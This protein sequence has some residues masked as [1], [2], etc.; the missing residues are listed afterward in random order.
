VRFATA[1]PRV[2]KKLGRRVR[3]NAATVHLARL[4]A[5]IAAHDADALPTLFANEYDVPN[6][7]SAVGD[8]L[9]AA[10][11]TRDWAAVRAL[12]APDARF[13]DRGRRALVSGDVDWWIADLQEIASMRNTRFER[14][15]VGTAGDRVALERVLLSGDPGGAAAA[16]ATESQPISALGPFEL[17]ALWVTEVDESGRL[18]AGVAFDVDDWRAATREAYARWFA[19][20]AVAAASVGPVLELIEAFN[21]RDRTRLRAALA[22]EFVLDDHRP[23][24]LGLI[25]G[26]DVWAESWAG[27]LDLAPDAQI[28]AGSTLAYARYGSVGLPRIF[29]TLRDGGT[30][31]NPTASVAIVADGR[32]TRL[33]LFEPEHVE[34]A[35]ARFAELRPD[36]LRIRPNAFEELRPDP[37]RIPPNAAS[38]ARDRTFEAWTVG[39]W[40]A[41]RSLASDDFTFEDR[42]KRA[43]VSGDVE[44]WIRNNQFVQSGS[45][46]R[47]VRELIGTAGDR[48]ALERIL[49]TGGADGSPVERE[50]LRLTEVDADGRLRASIRFDLDDRRAAFAEAHARFAAGEAA[51]TVAQ[52]PIVAY[53]VASSRSDWETQLRGCLARDVVV[54]DHRTLGFGISTGDELIERWRAMMN[55]APD[56][57]AEVFRILAWNRH[58]RVEA[59]RIG[60]TMPYG[61]GPFENVIVRVIVTDGDRIQRYEVFDTCD[62]DRALA[63]FEELS[64]D[65]PSR[66]PGDAALRELG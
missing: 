52:A 50:H 55:L 1:P 66:R 21:D 58:G 23:A 28:A 20:D 7:A 3:P 22:D 57:Q 17:E 53:F 48:I 62:T 39:D 47:L 25:E 46:V 10:L 51:S 44:L 41:L 34:A 24:R 42:G 15:L 11:A 33:E 40:A 26:A 60:G 9:R 49:W 43:L 6:A 4:D 64:A 29:G 31:E 5:A 8:R 56:V 59:V 19:S 37:M 35:L 54:H 16:A 32:I 18:T 14:Q 2:A 12:C 63:R 30:F 38:R 65:L 36:P 45:G 27:L 13:E 61:G